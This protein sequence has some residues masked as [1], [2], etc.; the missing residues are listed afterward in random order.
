MIPFGSKC[1]L[2]IN[3]MSWLWASDEDLVNLS[4][5]MFFSSRTSCTYWLIDRP[6]SAP[7]VNSDTSTMRSAQHL[8]WQAEYKDISSVQKKQHWQ[9]D[10]NPPLSPLLSRY[11]SEHFS[12]KIKEFW[13]VDS[14]GSIR[15]AVFGCC[16]DNASIVTAEKWFPTILHFYWCSKL[17]IAL[18]SFCLCL[19]VEQKKKPSFVQ[20]D[21]I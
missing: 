10:R 18:P 15:L 9:K 16:N 2:L 19:C 8:L 5:N 17:Q 4:L 20:A 7:H 12:L 6:W 21:P 13:V 14:G 11:E 1:C 3:K